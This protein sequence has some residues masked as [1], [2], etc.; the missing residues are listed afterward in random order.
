M[1][2]Q[3]NEELIQALDVAETDQERYGILYQLSVNLNQTTRPSDIN[4]SIRFGR[5]AYQA[6]ERIGEPKL[7]GAGAYQV[8]EAY[9]HKHDDAQAERWYRIATQVGFQTKNPDLILRSVSKRTRLASQA[10]NYRRAA[11]LNEE[12]LEFFT[13]DGNNIE[14]LR[15]RLER[16][17]AS[18]Q[19]QLRA[20]EQEAQDLTGELDR[21]AGE[22]AR[23]Q[24]SNQ[25]LELQNQDRNRQLAE[26][27][28][29]LQQTEAERA[30]AEERVQK[31]RAE[32]EDLSREALTQTTLAARAQ[33]ELA[34]EALIR[35]EAEVEAMQAEAERI[36]AANRLNYAIGV[37]AGLLL[38][39]VL[40]YSRFRTKAR[41]SKKL[42]LAN[43]QI[44]IARRQSDEL[45]ENML[46][47][48]IARELKETGKAKAR[49]FESVT[50][51]F[52]D[53]V[54]FTRTAE[55]LGAE[56]LVEELDRCFQAFDEIVDRYEGVEKIKTIGDAYMVASGLTNRKEIPVD[57]VRV[58]LEMQEFLSGHSLFRARIGLHTGPAVAGV[59]GAKKFAYD[60]W[61]DTVNVASRVE[62]KSEPGRVNVSESTYHLI[63]YRFDCEYRGRVE[64]K[65]KG[66]LEMYFVRREKKRS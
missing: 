33:E 53:F 57:I 60:I 23:L 21:L 49:S 3:S 22:Q 51:L 43:E 19:R 4:R 40:F 12:A 65:N 55:R 32:I 54:N 41:S 36:A 50:I 1:V 38:I 58:A 11:T 56:N 2:A 31:S 66:S 52:C 14:D 9:N 24:Q 5:Q 39:A 37:G 42:A 61:G 6:A 7:I 63:K 26:R 34:K 25:N 29:E 59:V 13:Q 8:G 20:I 44:D 16:E 45:L 64:V 46:P 30:A 47:A 18:L 15:A 17:R 62:G 28:R 48:A 27:Q 35:K 10:G